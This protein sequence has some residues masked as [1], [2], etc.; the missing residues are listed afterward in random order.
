MAD[1]AGCG[2]ADEKALEELGGVYAE[3]APAEVASAR[4]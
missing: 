3:A 4:L 2:L 1:C